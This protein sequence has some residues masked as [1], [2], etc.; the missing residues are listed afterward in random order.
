MSL[1]FG[2]RLLSN[3]WK[4]QLM[5]YESKTASIYRREVRERMGRENSALTWKLLQILGPGLDD[6][7]PPLPVSCFS[8][9]SAGYVSYV[10]ALYSRYHLDLFQW[11]SAAG[12]TAVTKSE[13]VIKIESISLNLEIVPYAQIILHHSAHLVPFNQYH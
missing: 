8:I 9:R 2:E 11:H 5:T 13:S 10:D 7:G 12:F 4:E 1:F 3:C 6:E